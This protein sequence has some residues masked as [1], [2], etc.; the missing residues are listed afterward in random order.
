MNILILNWRDP[1]N[2]KSGGAEKLNLHILQ[3]LVERGDSVSWYSMQG[4]NLPHSSLFKGIKIIRRGNILTHFLFWP[5]LL[6][7]GKFGE[8]DLI[9][10]SIHGTGY[11]SSIVAPKTKKIILICEVAQNI[12]DDMYPFPINIMGKMW[13]KMMF[14]FYKKDKFWT[15]SQSTKNDLKRFGI[16]LKNIEI[17]PM[18]FDGL[19]IK[20]KSKFRDPTTLF[21]GRLAEMKGIKDAIKAISKVNSAKDQKWHLR[22]VG[23]GESSYEEELKKYVSSLQ[24]DAYITFLGFVSESKKFEEMTK[25]WNI[26]VPSSRE[27]WG[28]IVPEANSVGTPVIAYDVSGL[29]D[30]A[31]AYSKENYLISPSVD[32]MVKSLTSIRRPLTIKKR[33]NSGWYDLHQF[34]LK[35][36]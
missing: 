8:V 24:M 19:Q 21:V 9:I 15:I 35:N 12:W 4:K 6:W 1:E 36:I 26:L 20:S 29:R 14:W 33:P 28:M 27:G 32:S 30:V 22:I 34:V 17:L 3:P 10:D 25:A 5:F 31:Q 11:L 2:P 7:F 16:E 13:E 18:G 23:R